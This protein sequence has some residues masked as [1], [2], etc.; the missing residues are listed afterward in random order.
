MEIILNQDIEK[1]GY[2]HDIVNV[3]PGYA[4][5]YL[6]PKGLASFATE[7]NKKMLRENL[8]QQSHKLAKIKAQAEDKAKQLEQITLTMKAKTGTSG[9]IFGSVTT[10]HVSDALK[11]RGFDIERKRITLNDDIKLLGSYSAV[12][13][14]HKEVKATLQL[15]VVAEEEAASQE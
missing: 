3:K 7:G 5:N 10:K 14:L 9:K 2:K 11:Q 12:V 15:E 4:R 6:I 1:L 13:D 8:R